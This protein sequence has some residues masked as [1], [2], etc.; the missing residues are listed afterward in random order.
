MANKEF[1][2]SIRDLIAEGETEKSLDE[3][4]RF[5]RE[6]DNELLDRLVLLRNRMKKIQR[7]MQAGTLDED[8]E[9]Q[10]R[11]KINEAILLFLRQ[12]S[13]EYL[14]EGSRENEQTQSAGTT[15][16]H[17]PPS[18]ANNRKIIY[19]SAGVIALLVILMFSLRGFFSGSGEK[20]N[21]LSTLTPT[22]S[23]SLAPQVDVY[24]KWARVQTK[25]GD[26]LRI[27]MGPD[28]QSNILTNVPHNSRVKIVG[29]DEKYTTLKN[30][31]YG[32]WL[33]VEYNDGKGKSYTGWAWGGYLKL[34]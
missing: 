12:L 26:D 34:E 14:A 21:S 7:D 20:T 31:Q 24:P 4:Y 5:V 11:A 9:Y 13:P 30:G 10:E 3:L 25:T 29:A 17:K 32:K 16:S 2:E 33:Q 28:E 22:T 8:S 1:I 18:P 23:T 27:R 19:V 15:H 6:T